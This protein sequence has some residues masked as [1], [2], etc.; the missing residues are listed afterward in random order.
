VSKAYAK[1]L[2]AKTQIDADAGFEPTWVP[3]FLFDFQRSLVE[4]ACRKGRAAIFA[5]CGLGK[6]AMELVWAENIVRRTNGRVLILT[7]LAVAR[8]FV[9]E[10]E[11]FGI[12]VTQSRN[13][14]VAGPGIYVTNY[15][16]LHLFD[17]NQFVAVV[18]DESGILKNFDGRYKAAVTDFML[19]ITYRL[20]ATATAAPNDYTELGNS[21]ESLGELGFRDMLTKFFHKENSKDHRGWGRVKYRMR[22]HAKEGFWRWV[23]SWAR[24]VRKPSD[25]GFDDDRFIL[26]ELIVEE[27]EVAT[28]TVMAGRLFDIPAETL[29]EQRGEQ[30]RSLNERCEKVAE[31]VARPLGHPGEP[32]VCWCHLND[33]GDLLESLIE[34]CEQVSGADSD[35]AKE[36]KLVAFSTGQVRVLV[37]K[38]KIAG[39]GLNWQ[40][41]GHQ[42]YFPSHSFEQ[43]YQC[44]HRSLRFGRTEPVKV[45]IVT[46]EGGYAMKANL[47][48]KRA[49][50]D[51]MFAELVAMMSDSLRIGRSAYGTTQLEVPSWLRK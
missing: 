33:E 27:H 4:W 42:T 3:D 43:W 7:P 29:A 12:G 45:D 30:R 2:A 48:R 50:A 15:E 35:D 28:A 9:S 6:T 26:P 38:P 18:C 37:T 49:A 47:E 13:G 1:F 34:D 41:C 39:F 44:V 46:T 5:D 8:Q 16:R 17:A 51:A 19:K 40:H 14:I 11:K 21:A 31:L 25:L 24:A 22:G 32:A 36:E 20:L 23:C 10:G